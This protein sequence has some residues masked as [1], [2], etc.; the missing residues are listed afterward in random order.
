MTKVFW[1]A[2]TITEYEEIVGVFLGLESSTYEYIAKIIAPY[3]AEFSIELGSFLLIYDEPF[4]LVARVIDFVPQGE[5]TSF[6]GQKWLSDVAFESEAIGSDIK[7]RKI[8]YSVK[9]KILGTLDSKNKF[10]PGLRKIPHI[11][12]RVIRPDSKIVGQI[13]HQ[14]LDEQEKGSQIGD[15]FLDAEIPVKFDLNELLA[16]RTFLFARAGYGKSNLMKIFASEW[17]SEFGSLVVFD[18]DGEYAFTDK[19][20][21]PGVM[22]KREAILITNRQEKLDV[23]N[24]Y[25]KLKLNL[26][27]FSPEFILPIIIPPEKHGMIFFGKLMG[28]DQGQWSQM[29]DL[30]YE[31]GWT[32][33]LDEIN[34]IVQVADSDREDMKP[35]RNNLI[36]PV[37]TL[38]DPQSRLMRIIGTGI[39]RGAI[40]IVDVSRLDSKIALW[41]TSIVLRNIF[42]RNQRNFIEGSP[43]ELMRATF[44][45]DEAQSVLSKDSSVEAFVTLAKEGRKY[46]LGAI[47]ITQ[48]PGSIPFEILSQGDNFFVFHLLSRGDLDSLQRANA[49]YSN[50]IITQALNEPKKGKCYMWTSSQPFVLPVQI[51][52]FEDATVANK[53]KEIQANSKLL[54]SILEEIEEELKSPVFKSIL[55]KYV[56]I[57]KVQVG[58]PISARTIALFRKLDNKEIEY[59]RGHKALQKGP[60]DGKEFA[61]TF[62]YY[63]DLAM[64]SS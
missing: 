11:T 32:A 56:E 35:I 46:L 19:K 63:N 38:H 34:E 30:F 45:I 20:G 10:I 4:K 5:L 27:E 58:A 16:K 18:P 50:D 3:K 28:L 23:K 9:I 31:R 43:E 8:S 15:Y 37:K 52:N 24:V 47:F 25:R 26:K 59:L 48:Q 44:G 62:K 42:N 40:I 49:H 54:S 17:K 64:L 13:I 12:S 61:I 21:R 39:G 33:T 7:R 1:E 14:V 2:V 41:L 29:V 51:T 57:E 60:L 22:D 53:A 36:Y 6:M 55:E